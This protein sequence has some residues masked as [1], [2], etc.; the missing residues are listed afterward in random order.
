[1]LTIQEPRV[2]KRPRRNRKSPAIRSLVRETHLKAEDFVLPCFIIDGHNKREDIPSMPGVQR[3]SIDQLLVEIEAAWRMGIPAIDLFPYIPAELKD[4]KGSEALKPNNLLQRAV[5]TVKDRFPEL[6]VCVDVALDPYTDHGHDGIINENGEIL[7]DESVRVL[8]ELSLA[9]ADAGADIIA[10][11]DMMD[12]RVACI[13]HRLDKAGFSQVSILSYT[14]KY[15]SAFYNPFR[16]ALGSAPSFGDKKTYQ[17]D[18]ANAREALIEAA[19]DEEEGADMLL[20]KP[21]LPYLDIVKGIREQSNLP[22]GV[23]HVSGEYAMVMAADEKGWL[24]ADRIFLES[25]TAMKRAGADFIFSYAAPRVVKLLQ[26][27]RII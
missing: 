22:L 20:V 21:G 10:P 26:K 11:S 8:E 2:T 1:M 24:D 5:K 3:L 15:A 25:L 19:L 17:M 7:N 4:A 14:A 12:G 16:D 18:P 9:A 13:R 27:E 23:Y 6:C